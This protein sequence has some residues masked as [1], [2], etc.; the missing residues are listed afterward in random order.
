M[1]GEVCLVGRAVAQRGVR[2]A[3]VVEIQISPD[4]GFGRADALVGMQVN[5]FVLDG[6]PQPFHEYV[7]APATV[8]VHADSDPVAVQNRGEGIT[9]KLRALIGVEYFGLAVTSD[10]FLDCLDARSAVSVFDTR[11][12][13]TR[14]VAQSITAAR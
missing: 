1:L 3:A 7:V 10:G 5:L 12:A 13:S 11:H 2:A 6:A 8:A 9:G 4:A 14:R